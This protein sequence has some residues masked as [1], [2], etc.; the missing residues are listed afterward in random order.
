MQDRHEQRQGWFAPLLV[1]NFPNLHVA[2]TGCIV[3]PA[4]RNICPVVCSQTCRT[5]YRNENVPGYVHTCAVDGMGHPLR[6]LVF[7]R[8]PADARFFTTL[9]ICHPARSAQAPSPIRE[10][11]RASSSLV[12]HGA[13]E[14][15]S[16]F[17]RLGLGPSLITS[18]LLHLHEPLD[19]TASASTTIIDRF[20]PEAN[21]HQALLCRGR[22]L[23]AHWP[24]TWSPWG[25][26]C[27]GSA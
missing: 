2:W 3:L 1:S 5:W 27:A 14:C 13:P 9:T 7:L 16:A 24:L 10:E 8:A 20:Q 17:P 19:G 18:P 22:C 21:H 4:T 26:E 23:A 6:A 11:K 25:A 12:P 15:H